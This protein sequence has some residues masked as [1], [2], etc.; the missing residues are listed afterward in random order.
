M[1]T[2]RLGDLYMKPRWD[3]LV[4][5]E[6]LVL[7]IKTKK[8]LATNQALCVK[9]AYILITLCLLQILRRKEEIR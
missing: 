5:T 4:N 3:V 9:Y 8:V 2:Q 6:Y 7:L 1:N